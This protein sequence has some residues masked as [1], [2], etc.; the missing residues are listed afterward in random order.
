M[1]TKGTIELFVARGHGRHNNMC[2]VEFTIATEKRG[3]SDC[4]GQ[5]YLKTCGQIKVEDI[6]LNST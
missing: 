1:A 6:G 3:N 5:E 4:F 2:H